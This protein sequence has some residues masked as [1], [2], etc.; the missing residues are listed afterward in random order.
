MAALLAALACRS[1]SS[2]PPSHVTPSMTQPDPPITSARRFRAS[3]G[4]LTPSP[5]GAYQLK[6]IESEQ[7]RDGERGRYLTF[8]VPSSDGQLRLEPSNPFA[9]WFTLAIA[10]DSQDC[11]WGCAPPTSASACGL[12]KPASGSRTS[13]SR[14]AL[15][16]RPSATRSGTLRPAPRDTAGPESP[17][18]PADSRRDRAGPTVPRGTRP[19]RRTHLLVLVPDNVR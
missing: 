18:R 6:L 11:V 16:P 1:G 13:G 7:Q 4:A 3:P 9:A 19:A 12:S 8:Q 15:R 2:H 10:W 17:R 5:S 14:T